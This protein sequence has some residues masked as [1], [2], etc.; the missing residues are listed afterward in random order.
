MTTLLHPNIRPRPSTPIIRS[1]WGSIVMSWHRANGHGCFDSPFQMKKM[2]GHRP[3]LSVMSFPATCQ[4]TIKVSC[5]RLRQRNAKGLNLLLYG[6]RSISS[7]VS[8]PRA[9]KSAGVLCKNVDSCKNQP[10]H[11]LRSLGSGVV[12]SG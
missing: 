9:I 1:S 8:P 5:A 6:T 4:S 11:G 12:V 2:L 10:E 7:N 3:M